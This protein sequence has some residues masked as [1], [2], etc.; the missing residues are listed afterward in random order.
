MRHL[1]AAMAL[2]FMASS[3]FAAIIVDFNENNNYKTESAKLEDDQDS[4]S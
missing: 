3:T 2:S 1:S 4:W